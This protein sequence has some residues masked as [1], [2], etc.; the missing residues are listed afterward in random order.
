MNFEDAV[1]EFRERFPEHGDFDLTLGES[2]KGAI[3][4]YGVSSGHG[5]YV[6]TARRGGQRDER[7]TTLTN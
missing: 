5:V 2:I 7:R 3:T 4:Q 6:I 1:A